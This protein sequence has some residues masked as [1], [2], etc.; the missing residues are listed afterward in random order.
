MDFQPALYDAAV[1]EVAIA[2]QA[3]N[4]LVAPS[5]IWETATEAVKRLVEEDLIIKPERCQW[6]NPE[7][8]ADCDELA[9]LTKPW[10]FVHGTYY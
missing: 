1:N 6:R 8:T 7:R 2:L 4:P 3:D 9:P 5:T 10:C